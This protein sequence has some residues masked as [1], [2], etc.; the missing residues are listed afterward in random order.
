VEGYSGTEINPEAAWI[1]LSG[2][3]RYNY[4]L[5]RNEI[6]NFFQ[7]AKNILCANCRLILS[8]VGRRKNLSTAKIIMEAADISVSYLWDIKKKAAI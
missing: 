8:N 1:G 6:I 2:G 7:I 3:S 5:I 4:K